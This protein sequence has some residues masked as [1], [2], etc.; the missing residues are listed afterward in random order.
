MKSRRFPAHINCMIIDCFHTWPEN[1]LYHVAKQ[2]LSDAELA[3]NGQ[4]TVV[5]FIANAYSIS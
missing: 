3:G 5:Q 2:L 4:E 1:T